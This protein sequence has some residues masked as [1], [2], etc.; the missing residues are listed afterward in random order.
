MLTRSHD[1]VR[2]ALRYVECVRRGARS[3]LSVLDDADGVSGP[4]PGAASELSRRQRLIAE[5]LDTGATD[6]EVADA[7]ELSV[8]TVRYEVARI[9]DAL[10]A[11]NRFG[12][13]RRYAALLS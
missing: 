8:R 2:A 5:L 3:P 11:G 13:G 4:P 10:G 9:L 12:A 7:L 1:V 6:A